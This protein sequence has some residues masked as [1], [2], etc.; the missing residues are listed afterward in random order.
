MSTSEP[1]SFTVSLE[2]VRKLNLIKQHL[3]H[4]KDSKKPGRT[5]ILKVMESIR[6]LQIDPTNTVCKSPL[7]VLFSRLGNYDTK[8][9]D[10]MLYKDRSLFEYWAHGASIVLTKD[11]PLFK[12][13][14]KTIV[15]DIDPYRKRMKDWLEQNQKLASYIKSELISRGPLSSRQFE[16]ISV[17]GWKSTGWSNERNVGKMLETLHKKGEII[18]HSRNIGGHRKWDLA[19]TYFKPAPKE[20]YSDHEVI[21]KGLE[22]SLRAFGVATALQMRDYFQPGRM[23]KEEFLSSIDDML[24]EGLIVPVSIEGSGSKRAGKWFIHPKDLKMLDNIDHYW[25]GRTTLLSPF[26]NLIYDRARTNYLFGFNVSFEIYVPKEK[27]IFGYFVL[28][29]LHGDKLIGRIDPEMDRKNNVLKINSIYFESGVDQTSELVDEI[30]NAIK[31]LAA[32]LGAKR[33]YFN[34]KI[35]RK[36]A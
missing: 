20:K 12:L 3:V 23:T 30:S 4:N 31:E 24:A 17:Q 32:F 33:I 5:K 36:Y 10:D 22:I 9:L 8:I 26:D 7:L 29:I 13:G 27:R 18:V 11:Y 19:K 28:P 14:M 1:K 34:E 15:S 6:Y 21:K 25:K 35:G 2:Q 16:D